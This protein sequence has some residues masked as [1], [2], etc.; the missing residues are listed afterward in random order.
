M[1]GGS[2]TFNPSI[3][4]QRQEDLSGP[5]RST[6]RVPEQLGLLHGETLPQKSKRKKE[7]KRG[8]ERGREGGSQ[9]KRKI[10][11]K[12]GREGRIGEDRGGEGK[13][14]TFT[15]KE[16]ENVLCRENMNRAARLRA[17]RCVGQVTPSIPR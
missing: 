16:A 11:G 8:R 9:K 14:R 1:C 6:K 2:N 15:G 7:G 12:E 5:A 3:G 17:P 4:R 10:K 13:E